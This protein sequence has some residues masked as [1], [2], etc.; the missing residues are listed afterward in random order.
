MM[1]APYSL[2]EVA[3]WRQK[4]CVVSSILLVSFS[5]KP[6]ILRDEVI[7]IHRIPKPL[8]AIMNCRI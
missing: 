8:P 7:P 2:A 4:G 1:E 6:V 5:L 3:Q